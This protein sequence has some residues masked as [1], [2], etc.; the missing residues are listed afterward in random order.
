MFVKDEIT[1]SYQGTYEKPGPQPGGKLTP[2][3]S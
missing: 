1:Y 3:W 2:E